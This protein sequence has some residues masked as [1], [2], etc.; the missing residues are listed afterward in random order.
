MWPWAS[1]RLLEHQYPSYLLQEAWYL[2]LGCWEN[3]TRSCTF[4]AK[5][6]WFQNVVCF[7][8]VPLWMSASVTVHLRTWIKCTHSL[9]LLHF[10]CLHHGTIKKNPLNIIIRRHADA[11]V[12]FFFVG[13]HR[14]YSHVTIATRGRGLR[15]DKI[16]KRGQ[17]VQMT[18]TTV[19]NNKY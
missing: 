8:W 15:M 12:Y 14:K 2:L 13:I 4:L 7:G 1:Y 9:I 3:Y 17:K 11:Y 5:S 10:I 18:A 19:S 6:L 16:G